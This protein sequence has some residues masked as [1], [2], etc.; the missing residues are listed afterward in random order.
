M[1]DLIVIAI[2]IIIIVTIIYIIIIKSDKTT[3]LL[4]EDLVLPEIFSVLLK[5]IL[6]VLKDQ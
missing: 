5:V 4:K 6:K 1:S 3:D 2:I